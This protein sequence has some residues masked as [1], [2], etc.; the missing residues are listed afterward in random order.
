MEIYNQVDVEIGKQAVEVICTVVDEEM[1]RVDL[2]TGKKSKELVI[3]LEKG[4]V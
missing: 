1:H 3:A 2:E 4:L